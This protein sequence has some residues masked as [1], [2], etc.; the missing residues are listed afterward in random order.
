MLYAQATAAIAWCSARCQLSL[1]L[2]DFT[3]ILTASPTYT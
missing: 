1:V 3:L 2:K